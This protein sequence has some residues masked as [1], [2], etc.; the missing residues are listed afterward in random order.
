MKNLHKSTSVT[1]C[2]STFINFYFGGVILKGCKV[3]V[4]GCNTP[5]WGGAQHP[6][7]W[8]VA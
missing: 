2:Y 3:G 7:M 8:G 1:P 6:H 4:T 5:K